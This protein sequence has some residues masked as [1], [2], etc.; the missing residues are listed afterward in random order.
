MA[1]PRA[2][3]LLS[4]ITLLI[5]ASPSSAGP[6]TGIV[7][8]GDSLSDAGNVFLRTGGTIPAPPYGGGHF[9][10]GPTWVEDLSVDLGLGPLRPFLA[11]G[12]DFAL[13][14]A[15]NGSSSPG[16]TSPASNVT[17]QV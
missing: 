2:L 1:A 17:Q 6:F 15:G 7:A 13:G 14:S 9:S 5:A 16:P 8:F 10:N 3:A 11:G 4:I 12:P